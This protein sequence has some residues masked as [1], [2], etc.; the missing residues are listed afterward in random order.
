[1]Q[2]ENSSAHDT[3]PPFGP[4]TVQTQGYLGQTERGIVEQALQQ[5]HYG[6]T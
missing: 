5:T 1:M 2:P 3:F 4:H 6:R